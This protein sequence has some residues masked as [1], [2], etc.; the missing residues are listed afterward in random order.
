MHTFFQIA[1]YALTLLGPSGDAI[2][3][4]RHCAAGMLVFFSERAPHSKYPA[5]CLLKLEQSATFVPLPNIFFFSSKS[6][7]AFGS[8]AVLSLYRNLSIHK[9]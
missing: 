8:C 2:R 9:K 3:F 4:G 1:F 5:L 7:F 6:L